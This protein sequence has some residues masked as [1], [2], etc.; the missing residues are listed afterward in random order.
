MK[1]AAMRPISQS[2]TMAIANRLRRRAATCARLAR[3]THDEES[4]QRC[5]QL[6][7]TYLQ[8]ADME[9]RVGGQL[10]AFAAEGERKP[11]A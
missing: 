10:S 6:E 9:D 11:A 5:L 4:R 1:Y 7:Q 8:L 2:S 3:Q